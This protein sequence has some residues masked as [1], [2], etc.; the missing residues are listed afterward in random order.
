MGT[1]I[2]L[3]SIISILSLFWVFFSYLRTPLFLNLPNTHCDWAG[4]VVDVPLQLREAV[5]MDGGQNTFLTR[6]FHN[7]PLFYSV[8]FS[9]C[10]LRYFQP[11]FIF[12]FIPLWGL[13]FLI[14]GFSYIFSRMRFILVKLFICALLITPLFFIFKILTYRFQFFILLVNYGFL[15][16]IGFLKAYQLSHDFFRNRFLG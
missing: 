12:S 1:R 10:Y 8:N 2:R 4:I 13:P 14:I 5:T 7:K 15:T 16:W 3:L 6:F 9:Q 11:I